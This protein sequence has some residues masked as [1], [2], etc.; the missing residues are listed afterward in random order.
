[1]LQSVFTRILSLFT[2]CVFSSLAWALSLTI[3]AFSPADGPIDC[4]VTI[5]GTGFT[6]ATEVKFGKTAADTFKVL[7]PTS[8]SVN[9][10]LDATSAPISVSTPDGTCSSSIYFS[11]S[12]LNAKD[13]ALMLQVPAGEFLMGSTEEDIAK[14]QNDIRALNAK[15]SNYKDIVDE[16]P[17]HKVSLNTYHIYQNT[18]TVAMYRT[19]CTEMKRQMPQEPSWKWQDDLPI[20][21]IQWED[22]KAYAD[23]AGGILPTEA[24]WEKAARGTDGRIFAWGNEWD[25]AKCANFANC[26]NHDEHF[27][28]CIAACFP[29]GASP[30]NVLD[31]T[32]NVQEWCSDWHAWNYYKISPEM[33]PTGPKLGTKHVLRSGNWQQKESLTFRTAYRNF[34]TPT[35]RWSMRSNEGTIGFRCAF[36]APAN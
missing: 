20:V 2:L 34:D 10:P 24:Q 36:V 7:S 30:Y 22:A 17:Q 23:W 27:G 16:F 31:I 32:G 6:G 4:V 25:A 3:T 1:M 33:N 18:V 11:I 26:G 8:I 29:D 15:G 35:D 13:G 28:P 5:N 14:L 12:L 19:F 9:V 21:G